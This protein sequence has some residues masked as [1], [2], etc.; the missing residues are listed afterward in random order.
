M[1]SQRFE[2]CSFKRYNKRMKFHSNNIVQ[3]ARELRKKGLSSKEI[4][5]L[6]KV[7]STTILRW[8]TDINSDNPYHLY[9]KKLRNEAQEKSAGIVENIKINDRKTAK[10]LVSMLYWCEGSKY[11]STN[12][13][14][15]S[16][17]DV[18]LVRTFLQLF[19]IGFQPKENK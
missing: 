3:K 15:F 14:S 9:A 7:G 5:K 17:S 11:P 12:F 6:L 1:V 4:G 19:R 2:N 13:V 10:I 8:C 18:N 16:N